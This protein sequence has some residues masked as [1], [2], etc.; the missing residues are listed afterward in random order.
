MP[1][2]QATTQGGLFINVPKEICLA[3]SWKKGNILLYGYDHKGQV[4]L[5]KIEPEKAQS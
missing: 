2:L 4:T 1:K 3:K 5:R